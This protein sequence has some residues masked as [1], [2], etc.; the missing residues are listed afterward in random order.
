MTKFDKWALGWLKGKK[1]KGTWLPGK[2]IFSNE[3]M[4]EWQGGYCKYNLFSTYVQIRTKYQGKDNGI[5]EHELRH[6]KQYNN[7]FWFHLLLKNF[8]KYTLFIELD[9]YREQVKCYNYTQKAQYLW[10]VNALVNP[11]KYGLNINHKEAI[12]YADFM[13]DDLIKENIKENIK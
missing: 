1:T 11:D 9:A 4:N 13:F 12:E 8:D 3:G 5:L 7:L 2:V 10:V 6:V